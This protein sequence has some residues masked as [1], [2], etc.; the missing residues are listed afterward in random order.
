[1]RIAH[2]NPTGNSENLLSALH[3]PRECELSTLKK[4]EG[5]VKLV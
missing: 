3:V 2:L 4:G 5:T 1:M